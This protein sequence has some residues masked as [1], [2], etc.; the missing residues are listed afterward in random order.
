MSTEY[1]YK[2]TTKPDEIA[3]DDIVIDSTFDVPPRC[4]RIDHHLDGGWTSLDS[5][6][7]ADLTELRVWRGK[8]IATSYLDPD[9]IIGAAVLVQVV[10]GKLDLASFLKTEIGQVFYSAAFWCDYQIACP[11]LESGVNEV[12]NKLEIWIR[13]R[14]NQS[15]SRQNTSTGG[16]AEN[17]ASG[18]A[19]ER[20]VNSTT[21]AEL[22]PEVLTMIKSRQLPE[23]IRQFD[24]H[25]WLHENGA[26]FARCIR[27]DLGCQY[28]GVI[29]IIGPQMVR[30]I[31]RMY[32]NYFSQPMVVRVI[33]KDPGDCA[34]K[35]VM[36]GP[37]PKA[38]GWESLNLT[39]LSAYIM[40]NNPSWKLTGR[41]F[42]IGDREI[43]CPLD[44]LI[45]ILKEVKIEGL[46][47][48]CPMWS[49]Y[50]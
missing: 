7:R 21:F 48:Q 27:H 5:I 50:D 42:V 14:I 45:A 32:F 41:R 3:E 34:E 13:E 35:Q 26:R 47:D 15:I 8:T 33:Q 1:C 4:R 12:G 10:N 16:Y 29:H 44:E 43:I 31:P 49:F 19:R 37:N 46:T 9:A 2:V 6:S 28:F 11:Y 30:V 40:R 36:I 20:L 22:T 25:R 24:A 38:S 17:R 18:G 39:K 23:P